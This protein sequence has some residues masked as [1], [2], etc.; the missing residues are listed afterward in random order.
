MGILVPWLADAA[1][2]TGFPV[3]EVAGWQTRGHGGF[4]VLE[5]VVGHHTATS[6]KAPGDYP[7]LNIVTKGRSD[8]AGPLCNY[9]LGRSGRIYVVA[10][11][12]AWHAGA[13]ASAGFHDLNDEYLGIEAESA[14]TGDWTDAQRD[15]YPKLVAAILHYIRRGTDRYVSHRTCALPPG[16]KPDPTGIIDAW[17]REAAGRILGNAP[18][19]VTPVPSPPPPAGAGSLPT[20]TY[21]MRN[22]AAVRRLQEWGQRR[23]SY[24]P[25]SA[26]GNYLDQTAAAIRDFQDRKGVRNGDGSVPDGRN[27]GERTKVALWSEGYRG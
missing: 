26:T 7:S 16:R 14:G 6:A 15:A 18:S 1:R 27:V 5:G 8:L 17:M 22:N 23:Y 9:G 2:S 4:R 3:T 24:F 13:S 25:D 21:G 11:G 12:V 20:L 19:S 10:A